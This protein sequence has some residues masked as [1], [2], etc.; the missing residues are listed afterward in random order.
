[1]NQSTGVT[2]PAKATLA[3]VVAPRSSLSGG[4]SR[5]RPPR[6]RRVVTRAL[7]A[8]LALGVLA[9]GAALVTARGGDGGEDAVLRYAAAWER[10]DWRAMHRLL[11]PDERRR[12]P[13]RRFAELHTEALDTATAT[14]L[15]AGEPAE[16]GDGAWRLPVAVETRAFG[17]VRSAVTLTTA[18]AA[19][20]RRIRWERALAFP[21]L[22]RGEQLMAELT[23]PPRAALLSRDGRAL[24]EGDGRVAEVDAALAAS[25]VGQVGAPP[26]ERRAELRRAGVPDGTPVGLTGLERVF[27]ERLRGRPGGTLRAGERTLAQH[28]PVP[29][30]AVTTTL[31]LDVQRAAVAAIGPRLGGIAALDPR[32]GEVLALGGIAFSGLQ[33]PGSTFKVITLAAALEQG[34]AKPASRYPVETATTIE[35]RSIENSDG[36]ACGGTLMYSFAHS[37]NTVFAPLGAQLGARELVR[38][39]EAFGFNEDP[40]IPGAATSTIP[41]AD[42]IGDDL[43][44]ASSAIGQGRVQATSLQMAV[45]AATIAAGG[46]RPAPLLDRDA[47]ERA[48]EA[49]RV[50]PEGVPPTVAR[51]MREVVR[52]GTGTAAALDGVG[53]AGKTG[54]AEL[55][56]TVSDCVPQPPPAEPCPPVQP[57]PAN[58]SAWFVAYAPFAEPRVALSV[59]L[60][61]S[62]KG[63][64]TAAPAAQEVLRAALRRR[65]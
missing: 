9:G 65:G 32:T 17:A 13:L 26:A 4:R 52:S 63:G 29:G 36:E 33:P 20:E 30:R 60:V 27:D 54:T 2:G 64:E 61:A 12:L 7:P 38:A 8:V 49:P 21:G 42:E 22:R 14:R 47:V 6:R 23:M 35:G 11:L 48:P 3:S 55:R 5:R 53:V 62:G 15:R 45:V 44:V 57:D 43:A 46:R 1:M 34:I 24:A 16:L 51:A 59:L 56:E 31:D 40:G 41:P 50:L 58:T 39:S 37:C 10:G 25:I 19:G 28:A 18:E